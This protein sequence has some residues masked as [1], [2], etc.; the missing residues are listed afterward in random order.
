VEPDGASLTST[1]ARPESAEKSS[2]SDSAIHAVCSEA[3]ARNRASKQSDDNR[4]KLILLV[5][6]EQTLLRAVSILLSRRGYSVLTALDGTS[7]LEHVQ[8]N[9]ERFALLFLDLNLPGASSRQVAELA[10][11]IRPDIPVIVTSAFDATAAET[12]FAGL[13]IS[14]FIRKPYRLAALADVIQSVLPA[15]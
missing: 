11:R 6:D 15:T 1:V 14:R 8:R 2:A 9:G 5:E 13:P 4:T 12:S 7:A 10:R 3:C